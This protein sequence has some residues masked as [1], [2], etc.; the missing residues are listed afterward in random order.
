MKGCLVAL[1]ITVILSCNHTRVM[2]ANSFEEYARTEQVT[3]SFLLSLQKQ[4]EVVL[5]FAVESYAWIKSVDYHIITMN[6]GQW[7]GYTYYKRVTGGALEKH[8]PVPVSNETCNAVWKSIQI[9]EAWKIKGDDGKDFCSGSE[10]KNCNINDGVS[11]RLLIITKDK[12]T[13]P[14]YY[15]PVFFEECCPG[16]A[17]RK[18]FIETVNK[19]K[20]SVH[21]EEKEG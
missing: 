4:N 3:D 8:E 16:N 2:S 20:S 6:S 10:K 5:A 15:E 9:N 12:I 1:L 18:L 11:W 19:I 13:D 21:V 14:S 7:K 17:G